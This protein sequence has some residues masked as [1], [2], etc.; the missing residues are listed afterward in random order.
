MR[1]LLAQ[2]QIDG[3]SE[4]ESSVWDYQHD[5]DRQRRSLNCLLLIPLVMVVCWTPSSIRRLIDIVV[6]DWGWTP[7]DYLCVVLGPLQGALNAL[8]YGL[9]PAVRDALFGRLDHSAQK[10]RG[11]QKRLRALR[12]GRRRGNRRFHHLDE[13]NPD[14][15]AEVYASASVIGSST[16]QPQPRWEQVAVRE[17]EAT[18]FGRSCDEGL[19]SDSEGEDVNEDAESKANNRVGIETSSDAEIGSTPAARENGMTDVELHG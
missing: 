4:Y 5:I 7:L 3:S 2:H 11:V 18:R 17:L 19:T 8:I 10:L 6:P 13:T 16:Q 15:G 12:P 1:R 14:V 9:T